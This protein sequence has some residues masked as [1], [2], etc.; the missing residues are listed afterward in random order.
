MTLGIS[1]IFRSTDASA[2]QFS[3]AA[4]SL[5]NVLKTVLVTGYGATPSLG[6]SLEYESG[7]I[8]VLRQKSGIRRFIRLDDSGVVN[9]N[10][11]E[12]SAY[13]S[14][15]SINYGTERMPAVG[16]SPMYIWKRNTT[17]VSSVPWMIIGDEAGFWIVYRPYETGI[18]SYLW[19]CVYVGDYPAWDIRNKWNFSIFGTT[20]AANPNG[21]YP[22]TAATTHHMVE[23]GSSFTKGASYVGLLPFNGN[24]QF[25][26]NDM[27]QP[28]FGVHKLGGSFMCSP[29]HIYET[30][31]AG[32]VILG[33][34]PGV[35]EPIAKDYT[36]QYDTTTFLPLYEEVTDSNGVLSILLVGV[37]SGSYQTSNTNKLI[38]KVGKGFRNVQ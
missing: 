14:M 13:S 3:Y 16:L 9:P 27:I 15:S 10:Y 4:G 18:L 20:V 28:S 37:Q 36:Y 33:N 23:R 2:P 24:T 34:L 12:I 38:F 1:R 35:F 11:M 29:I 7:H 22:H 31:T 32:N 17:A 6:W 8:A 25:G 19:Q 5:K 26:H 21:M 30:V